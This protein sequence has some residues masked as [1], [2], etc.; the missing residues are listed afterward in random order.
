MPF[1]YYRNSA[2][3]D[4]LRTMEIGR[5]QNGIRAVEAGKDLLRVVPGI[6]PRDENRMKAGRMVKIHG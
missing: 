6:N 4:D 5:R 1:R 2:I 3:I